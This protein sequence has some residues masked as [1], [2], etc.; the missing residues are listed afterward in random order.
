MGFATMGRS[1]QC[2]LPSFGSWK[3]I[4][5]QYFEGLHQSEESLVNR[6]QI[7]GASYVSIIPTFRGIPPDFTLTWSEVSLLSYQVL[8]FSGW[9][10][11]ANVV[12]L[13]QF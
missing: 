1:V 6:V 4:N 10:P 8:S 2:F 7:L 3:E 12:P 9:S 13:A 11:P 5:K